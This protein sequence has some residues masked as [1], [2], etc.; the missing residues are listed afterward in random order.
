VRR[1]PGVSVVAWLLFLLGVAAI[2]S[3]IFRAGPFG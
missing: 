2:A 3:V 1:F